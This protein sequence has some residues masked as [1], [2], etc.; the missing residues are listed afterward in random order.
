METIVAIDAAEICPIMK[1]L[2]LG[3]L[4]AIANEAIISFTATLSPCVLG[5]EVQNNS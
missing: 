5:L 1:Y 2:G 3:G 4:I